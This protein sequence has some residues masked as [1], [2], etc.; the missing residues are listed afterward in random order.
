MNRVINKS[1]AVR[2]VG[3]VEDQKDGYYTNQFRKGWLFAPSITHTFSEGVTL[4]SKLETFYIQEGQAYGSVVDPSVGTVTGGYAKIPSYIP[5][6]LVLGFGSGRRQP[7]PLGNPLAERT[8]L[9]AGLQH[10]GA[11]LGD[12]GSFHP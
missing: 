7:S 5:Q 4:T 6:G 1:T 9:P 10:L 11:P 12:G 2:V 8:R 3:S